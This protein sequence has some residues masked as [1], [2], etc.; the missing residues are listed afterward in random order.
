MDPVMCPSITFAHTFELICL[1]LI[2]FHDIEF[3]WYITDD[4]PTILLNS[5][6]HIYLGWSRMLN[7]ERLVKNYD[8]LFKKVY[9]Q[10]KAVK[11]SVLKCHINGCIC[12]FGPLNIEISYMKL[13]CG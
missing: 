8:H 9:Y 5:N 2:V 7:F 13:L 10:S 4:N 1:F 12:A 11:N 6:E 3:A